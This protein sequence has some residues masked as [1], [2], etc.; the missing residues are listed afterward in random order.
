MPEN[1]AKKLSSVR[2]LE[3]IHLPRSVFSSNRIRLLILPQADAPD[4]F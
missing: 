4:P 2:L 1:V 3:V